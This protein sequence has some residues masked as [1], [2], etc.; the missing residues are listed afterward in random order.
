[1][2]INQTP[3][4]PLTTGGDP[5]QINVDCFQGPGGATPDTTSTLGVG[6]SAAPNVATIALHPTNPRAVIVTPG[7]AEGQLSLFVNETPAANVNLQ[8]NV[9]V[10]A[11]P[12]S[13][14]IKFR[15]F[16]P[17]S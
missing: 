13:R 3:T 2:S 7:T 15:D 11:P 8:V 10:A 1:M 5:V 16:G 12:V 17:V 9:Q 4:I 6:T 14:Q